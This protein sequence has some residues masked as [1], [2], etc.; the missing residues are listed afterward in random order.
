M[1]CKKIIKRLFVRKA[2]FVFSFIACQFLSADGQEIYMSS[3]VIT[4]QN[5]KY[6]K[7]ESVMLFDINASNLITHFTPPNEY[8]TIRTQTNSLL[9]TTDHL[10]QVHLWCIYF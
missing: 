8:Y 7:V 6:V 5:N 2:F 9:N 3:E 4:L 1:I 10:V